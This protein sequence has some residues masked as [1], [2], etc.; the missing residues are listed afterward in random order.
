MNTF[1]QT[2]AAQKAPA[3]FLL[4][5]IATG[6]MALGLLFF[7]EMLSPLLGLPA[8]LLRWVS[9]ILIPFAA[10]VAWMSLRP[11][12]THGLAWAIVGINVLWT[13]DSVALL[14]THWVQPTTLGIAFIL[15][16]AAIVGAFAVLQYRSLVK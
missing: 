12:F 14:A 4:D 11:S 8:G 16:Q 7:S 6:G 15:G 9:Y 13:L 5:A 10:V 2:T 3:I 1:A